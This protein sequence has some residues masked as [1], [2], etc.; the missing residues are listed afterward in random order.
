MIDREIRPGRLCIVVSA[1]VSENLGKVVN[2]VRPYSAFER[3]KENRGF[4]E[5]N[6][7][8]CES[9]D[10]VLTL[11]RG[12]EEG[13]LVVDHSPVGV[14]M[15]SH[16]MPIDDFREDTVKHKEGEFSE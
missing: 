16:L 15:S 10:G 2:V 4:Y 6:G 11:R 3:V 5:Y 9:L 12:R 14:F 8:L 1:N 13:K 7:W